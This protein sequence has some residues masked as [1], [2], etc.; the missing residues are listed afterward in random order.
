V[1]GDRDLPAR[2]VARAALAVAPGP[3]ALSISGGG[4]AVLRVRALSRPGPVPNR[5]R[6]LA[7]AVLIAGILG[8]SAVATAEFVALARAWL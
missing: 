3:A 4:P 6:L 7:A 1:V 8:T 2:A 5:R